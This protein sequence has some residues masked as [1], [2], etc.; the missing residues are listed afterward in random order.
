L[1][2]KI[3]EKSFYFNEI[4]FC[5]STVFKKKRSS[6]NFSVEKKSMLILY[7][8]HLWDQSLDVERESYFWDDEF[9]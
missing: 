8:K 2:D 5:I 1:N 3:E 6:I 4:I 7:S 9:M